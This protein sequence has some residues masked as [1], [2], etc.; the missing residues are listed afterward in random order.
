MS[1]VAL[2]TDIH[3]GAKKGSEVFLNSQIKF[4]KEQF[5]PHLKEAGIKTIFILGDFF[6]NRIYIDNRIMS[7]V[8]DIFNEDLKQFDVHFIVGNHDSYHESTI[9]INSVK[10]FDLF[11]NATIYTKN[12][13][14]EFEGK[15]IYMVPWI[16]N[17]KVFLEELETLPPHDYCFGH[18]NF[19]NFQMFK[20]QEADHGLEATKFF[21]KFRLTISGHYHTRSS[22]K[23]NGNEVLYMGNP[24]HMT[25]S[26]IG[27]ERGYMFL[28]INTFE[29]EHFNNE[30]SIRYI[31][32]NYPEKVTE[33]FIK[34]NHVD[35]YVNYTTDYDEIAVQKYL[36]KLESY[37]PA[38]PINLKVINKMNVGTIED[39]SKNISDVDELIKESFA[40]MDSISNKEEVLKCVLDLYY[41]C[42]N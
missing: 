5:V 16:T 15:S 34:N 7:N 38:Y 26:D 11:E 37:L 20:N 8:L 13:S 30:K 12:T 31:E 23:V 4:F 24:F 6:D 36:E 17:N 3:F 10:I 35:L 33:E 27:D 2:I 18:F 21:D 22:K 42:I 39:I 9:E 28:D 29:Y 25:R 1:K 40:N 14:I 19:V 32:V 41:E